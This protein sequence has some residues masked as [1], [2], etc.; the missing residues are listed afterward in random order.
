MTKHSALSKQHFISAIWLTALV[1]YILA[2]TPLTPFH[3]DESTLIYMSRD[4]AYQFIERDLSLVRYSDPPISPA[5]QHLRLLNGTLPKYSIGLAWHLAGFELDDL[6]E[7]WDW[8]ADWEYN[9]TAGHAPGPEL[10]LAAR[11]PSALF[12]AAGVTIM[13]T[14]GWIFGGQLTAYLASL[15]YALNPALLLNGRRAMMEGS[16]TLF[17]LLVVLA[18]IGYV[19]KPSWWGAL[20]LGVSSG[21]ALASKHSTVFA[22]AAVF[23]VIGV[24]S[25]LQTRRGRLIGWWLAA[26]VVAATLFYVMNPAWWDNPLERAAEVL[27]L[28]QELL[29]I[30]T[31]VFGGYT[32]IGDKLAG[33]F[34]QTRVV[35]PQ[36]Y[37]APG[38]ETYIGDQI[39]RYESSVWRGVSIGG[40]L[41]GAVLWLGMIALGVWKLVREKSSPAATRA[42]ISVWALAVTLSTLLL[43]P[44][45]WQRY[46]L[47][48]YP[49][50]GLLGAS[51][52]SVLLRR[53]KR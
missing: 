37:E 49:V 36:Y 53:L 15:Y 16:P 44:L 19:R 31:D 47:P 14:L 10:L 23:G 26:G 45:E 38:W 20:M 40:S 29:D 27:E 41:L 33:F 42:V 48:V 4:Y 24:W 32:G 51:G 28:R 50:I 3:A 21:L 25:I 5:E 35:L 52:L 22:V 8:G 6:N 30:Q 18:G 2:G 46:Y 1:I 9:Q 13:F 17:G 7:Q 43:T 12:L 34:R 11:W 39:A